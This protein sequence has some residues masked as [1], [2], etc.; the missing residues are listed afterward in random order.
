MKNPRHLLLAAMAYL[1]L[2]A[3]GLALTETSTVMDTDPLTCTPRMSWLTAPGHTYF[4]QTSTDLKTWTYLPDEIISGDGNVVS[5]HFTLD[6]ATPRAFFRLRYTDA[7][8]P[9]GTSPADADFDGDGLTNAQELA[10]GTDP[11]NPDTDGDGYTD[12]EEV[13]AG[14]SPLDPASIPLK[15]V[16]AIPQFVP[17]ICYNGY[18]SGQPVILYLNRPIPA[19]AT[20][21]GAWV[22]DTSGGSAVPVSG[23]TT[24]LPG[25]QAVAFAPTGSFTAWD[26]STTPRPSYQIDF[27]T[28]TTALPNLLPYHASFTTASIMQT[29]SDS[30]LW[31]SS[32]S[33]G[34]GYVDTSCGIT[35]TA[36]WSAP[37]NPATVDPANVSFVTS[38]GSPVAFSIGFDYGKDMN[39]LSITPSQALAPATK[40]TV[41]LGTG[42]QNLS[43]IALA[44]P[45]SWSFT[46][47][48]ERPVPVGDGPYVTDVTP[49]D[50][51]F[52]IA[53]PDSVSVTFSEDMDPD[54]LTADNI[55]LQADG[56]PDLPGTL[57]YDE[58]LHKLAFTPTETLKYSTYY[59]LTLDSVSLFN[60][61][62]VESGNRIPLQGNNT[63]VFSTGAS[64]TTGSGGSGSGGAGG[65]NNGGTAG[66]VPAA[67]PLFKLNYE[68]G[69][70][71]CEVK[72]TTIDPGGT[73][74]NIT[75]PA[76]GSEQTESDSDENNPYIP[77][78]STICITP[79]LVPGADADT[80]AKLSEDMVTVSLTKIHFPITG[81]YL[82]FR[83]TP[84]FSGNTTKEYLGQLSDGGAFTAGFS[85]LDCYQSEIPQTLYLVPIPIERKILD[86][87]LQWRAIRGQAA[88]ALPG[89]KMN[90]LL[91]DKYLAQL[92]TDVLL[93]VTLSGFDWD[94]PDKTFKSYDPNTNNS[95]YFGLDLT[96]YWNQEVHYYWADSGE[97][98]VY[99]NFDVNL[100]GTASLSTSNVKIHIEKPLAKLECFHQGGT[101]F[102]NQSPNQYM[103]L[104]DE[105]VDQNGIEFRGS[106]SISSEWPQQGGWNFVQLISP[107]RNYIGTDQNNYHWSQ[108]GTWV[109]DVDFPYAPDL[110]ADASSA[111]TYD[112]INC[113]P[114][115]STHSTQ[116]SPTN[117]LGFIQLSISDAFKMYIMFIPP[118]SES[119]L[120]PLQIMNWNWGG[121]A[122]RNANGTWKPLESAYPAPNA[123]RPVA[124]DC[125]THPIW[126]DNRIRGA[127]VQDDP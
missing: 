71:G 33:P 108:N 116:D 102:D 105:T 79:H 107:G 63:F 92:T 34:D 16:A 72:I 15:V 56:G 122:T 89:Q 73:V 46:T 67:I 13:A 7:Y 39:R 20:I 48:P 87:G 100:N 30:G 117:G 18:P 38:N 25:R 81:C 119:R 62:T 65:G 126:S 44:R 103:G 84:D 82:V 31:V 86:D 64:V 97:K 10:A 125:S 74:S 95:K 121:N 8:V 21:T 2:A 53:P 110:I 88:H 54:T 17:G 91:Q 109:L 24:I 55:H 98:E 22:G 96:D 26:G 19:A 101:R 77:D 14:T 58:E 51:S 42:F 113:W 118:G 69:V 78:G 11:F 106:V 124:N 27:T 120:V 36:R 85:E 60:D 40:Y 80:L 49:P 41:T 12:G 6:A 111:I 29:S 90:L 70:S 68:W 1:A 45:V 5:L 99:V 43:G 50:F 76:A 104:Y 115:G 47:R 35:I 127:V 83:T 112:G 57:T 37:L 59:Q 9:E 23:T 94:L 61:A 4:I 3:S 75:L 32:T 114:L 123:P 93:G 52:N 66:T 28:E